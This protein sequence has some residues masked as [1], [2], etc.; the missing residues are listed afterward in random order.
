MLKYAIVPALALAAMFAASP[1]SAAS[2]FPNTCSNT[3]FTWNAAALPVI[4]SYCLRANG[5]PNMT[6]LVLMGISNQNGH[7]TQGTGNSTFQMSCGSIQILANTPNVTLSAYCR[8][9]SGS[10]DATSLSLNNIGNNNGNLVQ[11]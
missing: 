10:S 11:Q 2:T 4:Q 9:S 7:L 3:T 5:Q 6:T 8:T 1:A